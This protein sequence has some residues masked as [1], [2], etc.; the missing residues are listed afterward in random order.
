MHATQESGLNIE[1]GLTVKKDDLT[2]VKSELGGIANAF[3]EQL[4]HV[5]K[6]FDKQAGEYVAATA[7]DMSTTWDKTQKDLKSITTNALSGTV[8]ALFKGDMDDVG[9]IWES[10]W[11]SM[12][13]KADSLWSGFLDRA[14]DRAFDGLGNIFN[15][16]VVDPALDWLSDI[17]GDWFNLIPG[18]SSSTSGPG[19]VGTLGGTSS[20]VTA[21][22]SW[23]ELGAGAAAVESGIS[24]ATMAALTES[25]AQIAAQY[26]VTAAG[27]FSTTMSAAGASEYAAATYGAGG[28]FGS[29]AINQA[30]TTN[31]ASSG[32]TTAA[33]SGWS[34]AMG[35]GGV[36]ATYE[37]G[38]LAAE[39]LGTQG[40]APH[41]WE[42]P[43]T[44]FGGI[45][46]G[47]DGMT[48]DEA[49][50]N[51]FGGGGSDGQSQG[52]MAAI[53]GTVARLQE[54]D[55]TLDSPNL[56]GSG[57]ELFGQ[58]A[59]DAAQD[60]EQL[61]NTSAM[62]QEQVDAMVSSMDS[63]SQEFIESGR[64][65]RSLDGQINQLAAEINAANNSMAL[66]VTETNAFNERIDDLADRMG[67]G[68]EAAQEFRET[69]YGLADS[70]T[71]GG[72]EV[73]DFEQML[74]RF[75]QGT[76]TSL[77]EQAEDSRQAVEDLR[78]SLSG[79]EGA[80]YSAADDDKGL[81]DNGA[82][83]RGR[84]DLGYYHGG[85][86]VRGWPRAHAGAWI[87][88]LARDEV[89]II[90]RRGEYVVR[91]ES[92]NATTLPA[93][94]ALNQRAGQVAPPSLT[95]NFTININGNVMGNDDQI[96]DMARVIETRLRQLQNSRWRG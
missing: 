79:K 77:T 54:L 43:T 33:Q 28:E 66:G 9:D 6:V 87:S 30:A 73:V 41:L 48:A 4:E 57:F 14:L 37:I 15:D 72:E 8:T 16:L 90:A 23:L 83:D 55:Q 46:G 96:E 69:V 75:T 18:G 51:W 80:K 7:K 53:E 93:L 82:V 35:I 65:A 36:A 32:A 13:D 86:Y 91:S 39:M 89:P 29:A 20:L 62:T 26:G 49:L 21:V 67:L 58:L 5:W 3:Q 1:I 50:A 52:M 61:V 17:S 45:F 64:A 81:G 25:G 12:I 59:Q 11:D 84:G 94:K 24:G 2:Q 27:E 19:A 74:D 85:G 10:A 56:Q 88:S 95:A 38:L 40:S 92:V 47:G 60:L 78:N 63:M 22:A 34:T 70:F 76:L 42:I 31:V 44:I 71:L 68:D